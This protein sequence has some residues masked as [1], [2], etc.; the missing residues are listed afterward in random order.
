MRKYLSLTI[1]LGV[2]CSS[3]GGAGSGSGFRQQARETEEY[4]VYE[5]LL[6]ERFINRQIKRLVIARDTSI[7][8]DSYADLDEALKGSDPLTKDAVKDFRAKRQTERLRDHFLVPVEVILLSPKQIARI[9]KHS[10]GN[11]D[12]WQVFSQNYPAS[13]GL[14]T[15]SRVGFNPDKTQA[16]V[17][18]AHTCGLL[19][20]EGNY[21]VLAK[22]D[23]E[24][25]IVKGMVTWVS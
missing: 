14:I 20:G 11:K 4:A 7:D 24:W 2:L 8:E 6:K 3:A 19:C 22:K 18:V 23:G 16:L 1:V 10:R 13:A 15:L 5:V 21:F 9:F 17:F 12:G 25:K